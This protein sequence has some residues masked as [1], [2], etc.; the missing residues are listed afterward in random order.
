MVRQVENVNK[1][2]IFI[3]SL[4]TSVCKDIRMIDEK[5]KLTVV[6]KEIPK[7]FKFG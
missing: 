2:N 1:A 6:W 3:D 5:G 7:G 4:D